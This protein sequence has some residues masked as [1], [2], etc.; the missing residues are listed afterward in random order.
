MFLFSAT[1]AQWVGG[2]RLVESLTGLSYTTALFLFTFSVLVYVLI[3]GFRAVALSDTLLGIIM[4]DWDDNH[5]NRYCR[6][7]WW[8]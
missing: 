2:S 5:F 6:C 3:G 4:L 1:V 8:N 7:R